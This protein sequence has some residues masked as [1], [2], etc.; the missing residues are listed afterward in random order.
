MQED[1]SG[2]Y[3][4]ENKVTYVLY[5]KVEL[6]IIFKDET[7]NGIATLW[8][9][10]RDKDSIKDRRDDDE[11]K[12]ETISLHCRNCNIS[13][14]TING[15]PVHYVHNDPLKSLHLDDIT[16]YQSEEC[17]VRF[18][19]ALE[20]SRAGELRISLP[21]VV[22]TDTKPLE[23]L[24]SDA[25][26]EVI[27][28]FK[29]LNNAYETLK[30]KTVPKWLGDDV[31]IT[32]QAANEQMEHT[33]S[34]RLLQVCIHYKIDKQPTGLTP[35]FIFRKP[36]NHIDVHRGQQ[37]EGSKD[38]PVCMYTTGGSP[39]LLRDIDGSRCWMPCIDSPDQRAVFDVILKAPA[40]YE[41][42]CSGLL[43]SK[44]TSPDSKTISH[45][46]VTITRIPAMCIG[47]FIGKVE[48]Y[49]MPLYKTDGRFLVARG[50]QDFILSSPKS[51]KLHR[52]ISKLSIKT[53]DV[54]DD[55]DDNDAFADEMKGDND[56]RDKK[57]QRHDEEGN[58]FNEEKDEDVVMDERT[59][60][61]KSSSSSSSSLLYVEEVRHTT[62]GLDLGM[63]IIHRL[64]GR[65]YDHKVYSQIFVPGLTTNAGRGICGH[66]I[67]FDGFSLVD[68]AILH[69]TEQVYTEMPGTTNYYHYCY[70]CYYH[71][72]HY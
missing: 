30:P 9:G 55:N 47:F 37:M 19:A 40:K 58:E 7:I 67:S 8:L 61:D 53:N 21:N 39:G 60:N 70:Y 68:G 29:K 56:N 24:S 35:G 72:Y 28:R 33:T 43:V 50:L 69:T 63:R 59:S 15:T 31:E 1:D 4:E 38:V 32:E 23:A 65:K 54:N 25:P 44:T 6:D 64:V 41:V 22:P 27:Q 16:T 57:R 49:A 17:D 11:N 52:K 48:T 34:G 13:N 3:S 12:L 42:V 5:E 26:N 14:V 51:E 36:Y 45:R 10:L 71:Y 20:I 62:L 66:S 2:D 46:F 18:R